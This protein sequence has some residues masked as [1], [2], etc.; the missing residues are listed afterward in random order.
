LDGYA[1]QIVT[2]YGS[3]ELNW[4]QRRLSGLPDTVARWG[5]RLILGSNAARRRIVFDSI[6]GMRE[7]AP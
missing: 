7:V 4:L 6:F 2:R 5:V 1:R 3:G